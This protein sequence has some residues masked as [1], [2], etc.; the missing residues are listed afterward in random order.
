MLCA[1][2]L[3]PHALQAAVELNP[4]FSDH[5][6]IQRE[7]PVPVWGTADPNERVTV[8]FNGQ[9]ATTTADANGKWKV[10]LASMP[11]NSEPG[12]LVV[13]GSSSS[14]HATDVLV[15]DVFLASGQSN[16]EAQM[17]G[18]SNAKALPD[19]TD[20]LLRFFTVKKA[21]AGAPADR[22]EGQWLPSN[23]VN[24]ANC[25]AV[26]Y[27]AAKELRK[28]KQVPIGLV[29]SAWGATSVQTWMSG[30]SL[31][32]N[33]ALATTVAE[34]KNALAKREKALQ[35]PGASEQFLR[36]HEDWEREV[37]PKWQTAQ[38]EAKAAGLPAPTPER[39]EPTHPDPF[40]TPLGKGHPRVPTAAYNAM[41]APLASYPLKGILWYQ[42]ESN[43]NG[44]LAYRDLLPSLIAGWR[45][46]WNQGDIP[47]VYVQLPGYGEDKNP[48]ANAGWAYL[49]E[50][51]LMTL[52]VP[53]TAMV[54][55]TDLGDAKQL[56]P[57]N[58][59]FVGER[60]ALALKKIAY[61]DQIVASGPLFAGVK[62]EGGQ[63]IVQF[64]QTGSGL[65][66][67]ESP[68]RPEGVAP[69]PTDK[70]AGF[71][72]AGQDKVWHEADAHISGDTVIISS[73][74]VPEPAS[75]RYAWAACPRAN[76]YNK[77]GLPASP[78]RTDDWPEDSKPAAPQA[79]N[80]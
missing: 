76:L 63:A 13:K 29:N 53:Y 64:T 38:R 43:G 42:G 12:N 8:A 67:G 44:G 19:S 35:M 54:I 20:P 73:A 25:F 79:A 41:I 49:R 7:C 31:L 66:I 71:Y 72:I 40:A 48:V 80:H 46:A 1:S 50:A 5:A 78:F 74:S 61:G 77:E 24:T 30:E 51:Q 55:T 10:Q 32:K 6:V 22:V 57:D 28:S 16:M 69:L 62:F 58:K 15:G 39:P 68:W 34:W 33:P 45:A 3:A 4:I 14:A 52:K 75:V 70:L 26:A 23:P 37:A 9:T 65:T 21:S 36:D 11:A 59:Q 18:G 56:H 17:R 60:M 27:F 47:F 2:A